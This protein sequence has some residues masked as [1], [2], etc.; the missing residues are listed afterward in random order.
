MGS[1]A[2]VAQCVA[3]GAVLTALEQPRLARVA[4]GVIDGA[5]TD[6][7]LAPLA[8]VAGSVSGTTIVFRTGATGRFRVSQMPPGEY[9]LVLRRVGYAS[10]TVQVEVRE[11][12]TTRVNVELVPV[13][14]VLD[15]L[16][17]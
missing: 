3:A 11:G 15:A 8:E 10:A 6:T 17:V 1:W 9:A 13:G 16:S 2:G 12:D 7:S 14:V 5:V 4:R